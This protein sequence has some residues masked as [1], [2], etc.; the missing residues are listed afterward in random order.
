VSRVRYAYASPEFLLSSSSFYKRAVLDQGL[1]DKINHVA[2]W[3][4]ASNKVQDSL[5]AAVA[6]LVS[7]DPPVITDIPSAASYFRST[8]LGNIPKIHYHDD[9]FWCCLLSRLDGIGTPECSIGGP[10]HQVFS[11]FYDD[12]HP[13]DVVIHG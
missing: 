1:A 7:E 10:L 6:H 8:L 4:R 12:F 5:A 9:L 2:Q 3:A 13:E 11:G